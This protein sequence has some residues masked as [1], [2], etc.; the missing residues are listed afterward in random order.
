M[1]KKPVN[2]RPNHHGAHAQPAA[3]GDARSRREFLRDLAGASL[4]TLTIA[5]D[6]PAA[7]PS[8]DEK[9]FTIE[10]AVL[11]VVFVAP[12]GAISVT[13]KRNGKVWNQQVTPGFS[14]APDSI[15]STADRIAAQVKGGKESFTIALSFTP[16]EPHAFDLSVTV[17]GKPY[18]MLPAYPYPF[19]ES[20]ANWH[21]VQNTVG[22][23]MLM[24]LAKPD[25]IEKPFTFTGGQPW[26]G[27]TDLEQA[28][29][30]RL[31]SFVLVE[32]IHA[33]PLKIN[34]AFYTKGGYVGL[35]KEFR[36]TYLRANPDVRPLRERVSSRP[37]VE[38]LQDSVYLYFWGETPAEDLQLAT[39]MKA[40]GIDRA[41]AV[42]YGR[43][44]IDAPSY[45]G[46]RKLG[47]LTGRYQ[48]PTGNRFKIFKRN[49]YVNA[50]VNG[51]L[52]RKQLIEPDKLEEGMK[53]ICGHEIIKEW[54]VKAK[55]M[56]AE[57]GIQLFYFDTTVVQ[58]APCIDPAHP[59]TIEENARMRMEI[60]RATRDLGMIV[61]SGEGLSPTW[62][63]PGV[64][65]FEGQMSLRDY[66]NSVMSVPSGEFARDLGHDYDEAAKTQLDPVRR[67]PLYQ[68][69]FH[70]YVV[71]TWVWR[72][73]NF[74]STPYLWKKNLFNILYGTMPMWHITRPLWE[75]HKAAMI[76]SYRQIH[77]VRKRI[78]FAE[79]TNHGWLTPDRL[80]QHTDWGTG[81]RVIVN[82]GDRPFARASGKNVPARSF[83]LERITS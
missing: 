77:P 40:A 24:P 72:D 51:R 82:F 54:P 69:A 55:A 26:W 79:M 38:F 4:L 31:D 58:V 8:A 50:L 49:G 66:H 46:I 20:G 9:R 61:G 17:P 23:G 11:R 75:Q 13:D 62:A 78:G 27:I 80:V 52:D 5:T 83:V 36:R 73:T 33:S 25:E 60:M 37:A 12:S 41:I 70:D 34:Y 15:Q 7:E 32:G 2:S 57:Y 63:L 19:A 53:R 1:K 3:A 18:T 56:I 6:L 45:A 30:A 35:A 44:E 65:F 76:E 16:G 48:M 42:T 28:V 68:L 47:W 59:E 67:I 81:D 39:E 74:Q 22:E 29:S 10:N 43:H 21:Y 14:V 71:G 64:D